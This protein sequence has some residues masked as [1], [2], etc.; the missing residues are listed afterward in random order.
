MATTQTVARRSFSAIDSLAWVEPA[1]VTVSSPANVI[2][3]TEVHLLVIFRHPYGDRR[4]EA[5]LQVDV[6][7]LASSKVS[8]ESS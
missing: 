1:S 7:V 3:C 6:V 2:L 5:P 4:L 8:L